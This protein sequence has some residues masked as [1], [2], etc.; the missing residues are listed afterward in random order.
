MAFSVMEL[1]LERQAYYNRLSERI[2]GFI[3]FYT[4]RAE[5]DKVRHYIKVHQDLEWCID[6]E[7][8][9][10]AHSYKW[11]SIKLVLDI[12]ERYCKVEGFV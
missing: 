1:P 4:D 7:I 6:A 9:T 2:R 11:I 8:T 12:I 3:R 5:W 10:P